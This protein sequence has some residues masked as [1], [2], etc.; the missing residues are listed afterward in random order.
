MA[1]IE[2]K[3]I[4]P[5]PPQGVLGRGSAIQQGYLSI[6]PVEVRIRS[7]DGEAHELT[8]KSLGGLA[9]TEVELALTRDQFDELWPLV[10]AVI[11]KTRYVTDQDGR[12]L[13]VDVYGGKLDG[14][15]VA[16]VEFPSEREATSFVPPEW[17]G[18]E[19][20]TDLRFRN[21]ALAIASA[22]P[23]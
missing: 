19:V 14:L 16:E 13:E 22:P 17:L 12:T 18:R 11:E 20:T 4:V 15:V 9:R 8:V 1:E 23:T 2:R 21:A 5:D 3:F 10:G 7:R 6:E